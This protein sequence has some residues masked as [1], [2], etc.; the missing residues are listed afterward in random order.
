MD[1]N[2]VYSINDLHRNRIGRNNRNHSPYVYRSINHSNSN[3]NNNQNDKSEAIIR[4]I[5]T[6]KSNL[7]PRKETFTM[8]VTNFLCPHFTLKSV[9]FGIIV[10]NTIMYVITL[11]FGLD[12]QQPY[13]LLPPKHST[14]LAFG[15]L[16]S[17]Q[18][19]RT[20]IIMQMHRWILNSV[21]HAYFVHYLSNVISILIFG[22][23]T[24]KMLGK[25]VFVIVYIWSGILGSLFTVLLQTTTISVGASIS[26]YGIFGGYFAFCILNWCLM[27]RLFGPRGKLFMFYL[28]LGFLVFGF[29]SQYNSN[30]SLVNV[31]GHLGGLMFGFLITVS[32]VVSVNEVEGRNLMYKICRN[33][34]RG[35]CLG[36]GVIGFIVFYGVMK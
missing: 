4:S 10:I 29:V 35:I 6:K 9:S 17:A 27:D 21:L 8:F 19:K 24:E 5:I 7:N 3:N 32:W 34:A 16:D 28:L 18:L 22:A 33:V 12:Y 13:N 14:L 20:P 36:F 11:C 31:R 15:A 26:V 30:N 2:N 1:N 25:K 23:L